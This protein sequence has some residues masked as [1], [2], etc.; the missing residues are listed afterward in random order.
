[1]GLFRNFIFAN[2]KRLATNKERVNGRD[3]EGPHPGPCAAGNP[4]DAAAI[5]VG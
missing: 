4:R 5:P 2:N 1:L 3:A